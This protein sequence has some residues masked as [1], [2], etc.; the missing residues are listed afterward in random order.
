MKRRPPMTERVREGIRWAATLADSWREAD[1]D[2]SIDAGAAKAL[3]TL[4]EWIK[5]GGLARR[6]KERGTR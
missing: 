3:D 1:G 5:R 2:E 4:N 6:E